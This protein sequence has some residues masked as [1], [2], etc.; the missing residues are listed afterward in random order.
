MAIFIR[1]VPT[2][3]FPLYSSTLL[4]SNHFSDDS[5]TRVE[6]DGQTVISLDARAVPIRFRRSVAPGGGTAVRYGAVQW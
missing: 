3:C 2:P 5:I 6:T 4:C 1:P